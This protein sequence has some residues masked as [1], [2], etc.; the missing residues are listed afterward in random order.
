MYLTETKYHN[1]VHLSKSLKHNE[2]LQFIWKSVH[3][4]QTI[5]S[6]YDCGI[7]HLFTDIKIIQSSMMSSNSITLKVF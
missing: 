4:K 7:R 1:R 6:E 5:R 2:I 3:A